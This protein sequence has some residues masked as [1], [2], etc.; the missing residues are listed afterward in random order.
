MLRLIAF[1]AFFASSTSAQTLTDSRGRVPLDAPPER[2]VA[3][4]WALT[5]LL[6]E[7]GVTPVGV[8]DVEGYRTWVVQPALSGEV[9]DVGLRNEPNL[10]RIAA[11]KPDL[12]LASDQQA[13]LLPALERIAPV[14]HFESFSA[15]QDNA[16]A[17]RATYLALAR[18]L[19][20]DREAEARL[21]DL[22]ARL[23][24]AGARARAHFGGDV[25]PVLPI[26]LLSLTHLRLHGA[27]S[28]AAA[29]LAAMDLDHAAPGAPTDWGFVQRP[30]EDLAQFDAALVLAIEP[31]PQRDQLFGTHLWQYMPFVRAGR[32]AEV[33]PVWTFGGVFS[34]GHLAE[35]FAEALLTIDP[36]AAR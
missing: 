22:D 23:A 11:L 10:E 14:A 32:F 25:P 3:L 1:F 5:E 35:A 13:D 31:F 18:M 29:A 7:L 2:I 33:R 36:E 12:I 20:R 4:S 17:S 24:A 8:A 15:D 9:A 34:L 19:G 28:M 16:A 30:V 27:N 21:A 26:R 6:V